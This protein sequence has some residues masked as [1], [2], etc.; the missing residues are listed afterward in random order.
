MHELEMLKEKFISAKTQAEQD[1]Y[2]FK[3][4]EVLKDLLPEIQAKHGLTAV[5]AYKALG[6]I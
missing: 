1:E 2:Y 5:Q 6:G 3:F 4:K